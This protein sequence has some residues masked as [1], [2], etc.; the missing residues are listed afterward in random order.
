MNVFSFVGNLG[1]DCR[2]GNAGGTAVVNFAVAVKSGFGQNEQTIWVDCALWGRQAESRLPEF[3][4]K[5]QQ[6][7]V[8]GEMGTREYQ[9]DGETK[10]TITCRVNSI[11]L[12]GKRDDNQGQQQQGG[13][14]QQAPQQRQQAPQQQYQQPQQQQQNQQGQPPMGFSDD[15]PF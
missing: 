8:S 11:N 6:V 9:K 1:R 14:Q 2:T 12:V 15:I 5:G 4:V 13:Y 7:A 10:T 3:L